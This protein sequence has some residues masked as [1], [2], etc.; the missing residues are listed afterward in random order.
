MSNITNNTPNEIEKASVSNASVSNASVSKAL[1]RFSYGKLASFIEHV[2]TKLSMLHI[3]NSDSPYPM[4]LY[5]DN[6]YQHQGKWMIRTRE[7]KNNGQRVRHNFVICPNDGG[8]YEGIFTERD[9][10]PTSFQTKIRNEMKGRVI[11]GF[12][13]AKSDRTIRIRTENAILCFELYAKGNVILCESD[14]KIQDLRRTYEIKNET[15]HDVNRIV[16]PGYYYPQEIFMNHQELCDEKFD[17]TDVTEFVQFQDVG[18]DFKPK[19]G[20]SA[21]NSSSLKN[22]QR[23]P[24]REELR[25]SKAL[26]HQTD[27]LKD[28]NTKIDWFQQR[29]EELIENSLVRHGKIN[30]QILNKIHTDRKKI[31]SRS[32]RVQGKIV[33]TTDQ[34]ETEMKS[35][36]KSHTNTVEK[37]EPNVNGW[38]L[39]Y[40]SFY[41]WDKGRKSFLLVVGGRNVDQSEYLVKNMMRVSD[42]YLHT[43]EEGS[44][45]Y[46]L[47]TT[48]LGNSTDVQASDPSMT[49]I[50]PSALQD[51]VDA[52]IC[53]SKEAKHGIKTASVYWV[54]GSQVSK[55]TETGEYITKGSFIVRGKRNYMNYANP[56]LGYMMTDDRH[57]ML[58]PYATCLKTR[59]KMGERLKLVIAPL[60]KGTKQKH[61]R[62]KVM[63]QFNLKSVPDTLY[64]PSHMKIM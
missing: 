30:F 35:V 57:I 9:R 12:E 23:N 53:F 64:L 20:K 21:G 4:N 51:A 43:S 33:E 22:S 25:L 1:K 8:V 37:I 38:Y 11:Y 16:R 46:V 27:N 36:K 50:D 39:P 10:L 28:M 5:F 44:G 52:I 2:N 61:M 31:I 7:G 58:M 42:I 56:E 41:V 63:A 3:N 54:D 17:R 55:T 62:E 6:I 24:S 47:F 48:P 18:Y 59:K 29:T 14:G 40:H 19:P 34:L 13:I 26:Q 45:S 49:D 15:E 32:F 60:G